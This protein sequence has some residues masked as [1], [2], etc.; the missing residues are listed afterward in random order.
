MGL[1]A[2]FQDELK[3]AMKNGDTE[4]RDTIRL[5]QS[6]LKNTA[7]DLRKPLADMSDEDVQAVIRKLVKQRKDSILQYRAGS[8]EDLAEREE[9]ELRIL[10]E[11]LPVEMEEEEVRVIVS[12]ALAEC[13]AVSRKDLGKAMGCAMKTIAGRASG[14]TVRRIVMELLPESGSESE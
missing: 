12:G 9:R 10:S 1:I 7:I 5:L 14:D 2:I 6:A 13:G 8:R 3:A 4:R 11:F